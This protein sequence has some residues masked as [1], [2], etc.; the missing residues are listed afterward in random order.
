MIHSHIGS[1]YPVFSL[2]FRMHSSRAFS[3]RI[4]TEFLAVKQ[5]HRFYGLMKHP[6]IGLLCISPLVLSD[7]Y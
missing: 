5:I 7:D 3:E 1:Y 6:H 4:D 2:F